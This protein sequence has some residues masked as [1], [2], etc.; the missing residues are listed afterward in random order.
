MKKQAALGIL[1]AV[2]ALLVSNTCAEF[3]EEQRKAV[4][5]AVARV[6]GQLKSAAA[7]K[8]KRICL[9]LKGDQGKFAE[10]LLTVALRR[11][12]MIPVIPPETNHVDRTSVIAKMDTYEKFED[13]GRFNKDQ[14]IQYGKWSR[15]EVVLNAEISFVNFR[16]RIRANI[17]MNAL[18]IENG[19]YI[20]DEYVKIHG[21]KVNADLNQ[22]KAERFVLKSGAIRVGVWS[23]EADRKSKSLADIVAG[24]TKEALVKEGYLM[25][26]DARQDIIVSLVTQCGS[27]DKLGQSFIF[28]GMTRVL[29][30]MVGTQN[31]ALGEK[32]IYARG[33]RVFGEDAAERKLADKLT[34]EV[35]SWIRQTIRPEKLGVVSESF[36]LAFVGQENQASDLAMAEA[37]RKAVESMPG[38]RQV[39]GNTQKWDGDCL[40][41][42]FRAIYEPSLYRGGILGNAFLKYPKLAE[43]LAE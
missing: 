35:V 33:E 31:G 38:V 15:A 9:I 5:D 12:E 4:N 7:L 28:T 36:T 41:I 23:R 40:S 24:A 43:L 2:T 34:G 8:G 18:D 20:W 37:F 42:L 14:I 13:F 22:R 26:G 17:L 30:K 19:G 1:F 27:F 10:S 29:V 3:T 32:P 11:A 25:E 16:K 6:E 39:S 21:S